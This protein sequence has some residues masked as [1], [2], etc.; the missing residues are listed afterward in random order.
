MS[1]I[2]KWDVAKVMVMLPEEGF[3]YM[4]PDEVLAIENPEIA[5]MFSEM[6]PLVVEIKENNE[7][8]LTMKIPEE[9]V[10]EARNEGTPLTDDGRV[11]AQTNPWK[12]EDGNFFYDTF[13]EREIMGEK[14]SSWD[15]LKFDEDGYLV[16]SGGMALLKKVN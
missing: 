6:L 11:I 15:E 2:G 1:I 4:T 12:E 16:F 9:A 7:M 10:E 14:V 5:E 3:K 13:E 8:L